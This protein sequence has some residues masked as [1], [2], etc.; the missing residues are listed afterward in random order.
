M[1][2]AVEMRCAAA[3]SGSWAEGM[4]FW[5]AGSIEVMRSTKRWVDKNKGAS[6]G[7]SGR[8]RVSAIL[9]GFKTK[10]L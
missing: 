1:V 6:T 2:S 8:G 5:L 4:G 10:N 9:D 7:R 3:D